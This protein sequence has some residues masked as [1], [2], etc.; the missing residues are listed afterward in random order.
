MIGFANLGDINSHLLEFEKSLGDA[1][2]VEAERRPLANSM[3]VFLVKGSFSELQFPYVQFPCTA[4][5][6]DQMYEPFWEAMSHLE[7]CGFRV[8][9]LTCDGLAANRKLFRLHNP[10]STS[11]VHKVANPS[12]L[13]VE[14]CTYWLTH[15]ILRQ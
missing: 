9:A 14:I 4:L 7:L 6:G 10:G 12:L 3:L 8:L 15:L 1:D 11:L 5:S 2:D 13:M